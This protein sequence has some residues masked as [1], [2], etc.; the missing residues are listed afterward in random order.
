LQCTVHISQLIGQIIYIPVILLT[1]GKVAVKV[2]SWIACKHFVYL[3][4]LF[5]I[6]TVNY[7]IEY[8]LTQLRSSSNI[9]IRHSSILRHLNCE[10]S[11]LSMREGFIS[12]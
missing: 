4:N 9:V 12:S 2:S 8:I 11:S 5:A 10:R 3:Y 7:D 6:C 1:L